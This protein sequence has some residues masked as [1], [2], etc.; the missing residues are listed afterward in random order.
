MHC[1]ASR[2]VTNPYDGNEPYQTAW[3]QG[4]DY[5]KSNPSD[6]QPQTPD[7]SSWGYEADVTAY[8]GQ[9]WQEGALA[10]R[11]A[12]GAGAGAASGT[13]DGTVEIPADLADELARFP[14]YYPESLAMARAGDADTYFRDVVGIEIPSEN[15]EPVA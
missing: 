12:S 6:S 4:D 2:S 1:V 13:S 8:L 11:D 10:G 9:V 14:E 3:H 15:D 7:F 5:A